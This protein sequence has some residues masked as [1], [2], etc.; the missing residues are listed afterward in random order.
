M[1]ERQITLYYREGC[2]LCEEME[3]ALQDMCEEFHF[4]VDRIDIDQNEVLKKKYNADV[5]VAMYQNK[6][7]FRHFFNEQLFRDAFG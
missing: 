4:S 5:P 7:L 1:V 6:L 2:H 3:D